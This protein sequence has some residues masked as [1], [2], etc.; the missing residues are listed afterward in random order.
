MTIPNEKENLLKDR[1]HFPANVR[2]ACQTY[3]K[4]NNVRLTRIIRDESDIDLYVGASA[5]A[6]TENIGIEKEVIIC[7]ID[8]R[9]FTHFVATNLAFDIIHIM[10]KLCN[11]FHAIIVEEQWKI[12]ETMGDG[13]YAVFGL[14]T[15]ISW[16]ADAAVT[17]L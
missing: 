14:N 5:A 9:D 7:F 16:S 11:C 13:L 6:F 12:I 15:D 1:M 3:V 10:R 2:L 17:F 4:G 8:I